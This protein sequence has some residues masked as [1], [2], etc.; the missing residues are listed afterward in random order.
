MAKIGEIQEGDSVICPEDMG[1][2]P[3]KAIAKIVGT[4]VHKRPNKGEYV[5]ISVLNPNTHRR[6]TWSSNRLTK[7]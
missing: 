3:F 4:K 7:V 1:E 2:P 6:S 5:W